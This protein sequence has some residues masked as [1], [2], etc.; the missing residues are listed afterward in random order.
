MISERY[1]APMEPRERW[2]VLNPDRIGNDASPRTRRILLAVTIAV[3]VVV[4]AA[5]AWVFLA[6]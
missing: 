3:G 6:E 2:D 1:A 5:W 4:V